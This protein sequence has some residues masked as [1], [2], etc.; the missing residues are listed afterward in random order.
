MH[1]YPNYESLEYVIDVPNICGLKTNSNSK[2]KIN[3]FVKL[4]DYLKELNIPE[5]NIINYTD[6]NLYYN[7]D[8]P[9]EY[10]SLV[11]NKKIIPVPAGIKGDIAII[12]N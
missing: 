4:I 7:I 6:S 10:S 9:R 8:L 12:L 1:N 5:E 11:N 3:N 2:P